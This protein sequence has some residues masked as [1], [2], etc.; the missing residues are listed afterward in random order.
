MKQTI[1]PQW[2]IFFESYSQNNEQLQIQISSP[3]YCFLNKS[4]SNPK[5]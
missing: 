1:I 5:I 3:D 2:E 4:W